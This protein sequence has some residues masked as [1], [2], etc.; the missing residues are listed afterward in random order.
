MDQAKSELVSKAERVD[1][2]LAEKKAVVV[3]SRLQATTVAPECV[4]AGDLKGTFVSPRGTPLVWWR[5]VDA[6]H[7]MSFDGQVQ[8]GWPL[9]STIL[10]SAVRLESVVSRQQEPGHRARRHCRVGAR[11]CAMLKQ[12]LE[13]DLAQEKSKTD[14]VEHNIAAQ[15][16]LR[17]PCWHARRFRKRGVLVRKGSGRCWARI[18]R[19]TVRAQVDV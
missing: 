9:S 18:L 4:S 19:G 11:N 1:L 13:D 5:T 15:R 8:V 2:A 7:P 10:Q 3:R 17:Q 16:A 14:K 6:H 12:S